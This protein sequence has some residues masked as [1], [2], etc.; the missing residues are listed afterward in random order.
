V[1]HA[2]H[3]PE[4]PSLH[5]A[6]RGGKRRFYSAQA[7]HDLLDMVDAHREM[8]PILYRL[9]WGAHGRAHQGP[10]R[11]VATADRGDRVA[12]P[13]T[14]LLQRRAQQCIGPLAHAAPQGKTLVWWTSCSTLPQTAS[15]FRT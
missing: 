6:K 4:C 3:S 14:L 11:G 10:Q 15:K 2:A 5:V 9:H 8:K 13:P 1:I 12:L 7:E